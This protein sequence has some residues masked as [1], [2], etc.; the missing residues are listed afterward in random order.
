VLPSSSCSLSSLQLRACW[1]LLPCGIALGCRKKRRELGDK[2]DRGSR[3]L[4][5]R[6]AAIGSE[7]RAGG[8]NDRAVHKRGQCHK[9]QRR[10][11]MHGIARSCNRKCP[12]FPFFRC[13]MD[14]TKRVLSVVQYEIMLTGPGLLEKSQ[15]IRR[16]ITLRSQLTGEDGD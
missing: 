13:T 14:S 10:D 6:M 12:L 5:Q 16:R 11:Q 15:G 1:P 3:P 9:L 8:I 4:K 7:N 2:G